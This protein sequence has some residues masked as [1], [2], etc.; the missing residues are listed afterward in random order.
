MLNTKIQKPFFQID[1]CKIDKE[2]KQRE[3]PY[4]V[5][6]NHSMNYRFFSEAQS[7]PDFCSGFPFSLGNDCLFH[8]FWQD[9][10]TW[11]I[12]RFIRS[13]HFSLVLFFSLGGGPCF[14][15]FFLP[16]SAGCFLI[17]FFGKKKKKKRE[18]WGGNKK[19]KPAPQLFF[20]EKKGVG[21]ARPQRRG[22]KKSKKKRISARTVRLIS[23]HRMINI[24]IYQ[25]T[26]Q[27]KY[28]ELNNF[29]FPV[30]CSHWREF[31]RPNK[32]EE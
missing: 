16:P 2:S 24:S 20:F 3:L 14:F 27:N 9:F 21:G 30:E 28:Y 11:N 10:W 17:F 22:P 6:S 25:I 29:C 8:I 18:G 31:S 5:V 7:F 23:L 19:K 12:Y 13:Y 32:K 4:Q 15:Y 26:S 1:I